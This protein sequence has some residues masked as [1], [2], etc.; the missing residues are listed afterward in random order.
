MIKFPPDFI[1]GSAT[2][3]FQIEGGWNEDGKGPS[4][5]DAFCGIPGRVVNNDT[6]E[7]ACDHYHR[8][9][10]DVA[11]M[12]QMGLPAYRFS[13][14][15]PRIFPDGTGKPS[16]EGIRFYSK[17]IDS[18]LENDIEPW[19]TLYHWDLPLSLQME[20]D[21][22]INPEIADAFAA[23][24]STCFE[25]FGDRI[26]NWVTFNEA[27]VVTILGHGQGVFV[28][29]A[30]VL[31]AVAVVGIALAGVVGHIPARPLE[32]NGGRGKQFLQSSPAVLTHRLEC[33]GELLDDLEALLARLAF[34]LIE[35][36]RVNPCGASRT[37]RNR[38]LVP[39]AS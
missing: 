20:K 27:W 15:W 26:K 8:Y 1:W 32:L 23:Y 12:K 33:V 5:W 36:H 7:I 38:T 25:H 24:A 37:K 21:G 31:L 34:V 28:L 3:S 35:R 4:I 29:F 9:Q 39:I 17:L 13:I 10:E 14:S 18:L 22:W 30:V 19:V 11:L 6:G 16:K 2:S